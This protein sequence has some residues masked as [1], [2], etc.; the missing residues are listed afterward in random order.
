[1]SRSNSNLCRRHH[2]AIVMLVLGGALC[3]STRAADLKPVHFRCDEADTD[4]SVGVDVDGVTMS[5]VS[6]GKLTSPKEIKN[7][8]SW[9]FDGRRAI[10]FAVPSNSAGFAE[11]FTWEGFFLTPG[12]NKFLP[13][14]GIADR[15]VTQFAFNKGDWTRLAIGLVADKAG[16]ARLCV[17]LEG[18]EGRTFGSGRQIVTPDRWHHFALVHE[19]TKSAARISWYLD[20]NLTGELF[21]GGQANQNI[22]RPPGK[23]RFTIGARLK[24]GGQVNRGFEGLVDEVRLSPQP[25]RIEQFL[26]CEEPILERAIDT[27]SVAANVSHTFWQDR[28]SWARAQSSQWSSSQSERTSID[29]LLERKNLVTETVGDAAF[30][31][32]LTLT[33]LGRIPSLEEVTEFLGD[34][35][36]DKRA[37]AIDALLASPEWADNWVGYWQD[38]LAENPSV[39]FPTLNNSGAFRQWIYESFRANKPF[40]QFATE[41]ILM[42]ADG[43][44]TGAASNQLNNSPAGFAL[45]T[46]NDVP[47]AMRS[48][49]AMKA[50]AAVDLKCARCHDS[51]VDDFQQADLFL[52]AA[53]LNGKSLEVPATSLAAVAKA[54]EPGLIKSSLK[55]GQL[56]RPTGLTSNWL[57]NPEKAHSRHSIAPGSRGELA[58]LITSPRNS[59]FSDVIVNRVWKLYFGKGLIEP[60]DQWNN[61]PDSSHPTLLRLLSAELVEN[62]YDLKFLARR[63]LNSDAWQAGREVRPRMSAEQLLDSLFFAVG[64]EFQAETM[65]VHATD[66]GAVQLPKPYRAW[67]LAALPNERDRPALGMPVNQTIVD[68]MTAFGWNG[69]RQ[70]PKSERE[71]RTSALQPLIVFNG[72]MTQRI[73]RLSDRSRIT[74]MCLEKIPV[75]A[76][77]DR[78]FLSLL[79]RN[80]D[81]DEQQQFALML[82]PGYMQRRTGK[83]KH[84]AKPL[85]VFQPDWRKHLEAEQ[86][87]L[88]LEA[89]KR[90]ALGE[91]PTDRLT[92]DFRER[93]EDIIWAL[94]NTPEFVVIP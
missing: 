50:F 80:P 19:G 74:E 39:V 27:S 79:S 42:Q 67:Q 37:R 38:V 91:R 6:V 35:R 36:P 16:A 62:G 2:L 10:V 60:V 75:E 52:L 49:V 13:E 29:A 88:M 93:V 56:I 47:M 31:R 90:V 53:Y 46:G 22:L 11:N 3:C 25:L 18:F 59:R 24:T 17:E 63:I 69:N 14:T 66:P 87:R 57:P 4:P 71:Q 45:A 64:K 84:P 5:V 61:R 65:G 43:T 28:H 23:A 20:Y 76:L 54:S 70:Q 12:S 26:R 7:A 68:V 34:N 32:R 1:M 9:Q 48:H 85:S 40:D 83:P 92:V 58:A 55:P 78:L 51:P 15:L 73:T 82:R 30:L 72:L 8:G 89:R 81:T 44:N 94:I 77:V 41:L 33:L 86:T 21:L